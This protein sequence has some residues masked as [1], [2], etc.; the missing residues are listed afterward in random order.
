ME[1]RVGFIGVGRLGRPLAMRLLKAGFLTHVHDLVP[2]AVAPFVEQGVANA[3]TPAEMGRVCDVVLLALPDSEAVESVVIGPYGLLTGAVP[4][5]I[6]IDLGT[7]NPSSTRRIAHLLTNIGAHFLDAPVSGGV[8]RAADGTLSMMV[9]G[10][11]DVLERCRPVLQVMAQKITHLGAVGNGH[12]AKIINNFLLAVHM[13]AASEAL[14]LAAACGL[15]RELVLEVINNGTGQSW[16][17]REKLGA[18]LKGNTS[19]TFALHLMGKEVD[20]YLEMGRD[21]GLPLWIGGVIQ[22]VLRLALNEQ[23][24]EVDYTALYNVFD[25]WVTRFPDGAVE[26][27]S[28]AGSETFTSSKTG[29]PVVPA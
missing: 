11:K 2:A 20:T 26:K 12:T 3:A 4:G 13:A 6:V 27:I 15:D 9:G 5:L 29:E 10:P 7:S 17:T 14:T 23:G 18:V 24:A 28:P 25:K 16:V 22:Q 21:Y 19:L 8:R 1:Y